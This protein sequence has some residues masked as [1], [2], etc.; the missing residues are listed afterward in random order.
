MWYVKQI[1]YSVQVEKSSSLKKG[2][3]CMEC[4]VRYFLTYYMHLVL[5]YI[6]MLLII[7]SHGCHVNTPSFQSCL[8]RCQT[9]DRCHKQRR[10]LQ[11]SMTILI[12]LNR[13]KQT[14]GSHKRT[15][16]ATGVSRNSIKRL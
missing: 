7:W 14:Q 15:S 10:L 12:K 6:L 5:K 1:L 13:C 11:M 4:K 2:V 9:K 8:L 16:D 3:L